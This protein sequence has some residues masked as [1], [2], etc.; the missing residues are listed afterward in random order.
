LENFGVH[1]T[2]DHRLKFYIYDFEL[3]QKYKDVETGKPTVQKI[4]GSKG[5]GTTESAPLVQMTGSRV[6]FFEDFLKKNF[7]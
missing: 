1:I 2:K 3:S 6:Y 4:R 7:F 5:D